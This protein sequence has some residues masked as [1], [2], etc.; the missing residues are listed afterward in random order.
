MENASLSTVLL[1][2]SATASALLAVGLESS[3]PPD[4]LAPG[5]GLFVRS[6]LGAW[7]GDLR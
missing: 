5:G 1:P 3:A 4:A 7:R 6:S 2:P